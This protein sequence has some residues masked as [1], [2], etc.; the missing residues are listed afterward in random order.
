MHGH[1]NVKFV[2]VKVAVPQVLSFRLS[3]EHVT[4]Y[5]Q[6]AQHAIAGKI[7]EQDTLRGP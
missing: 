3:P 5:I 1:L 6:K 7:K 2:T 4:Q